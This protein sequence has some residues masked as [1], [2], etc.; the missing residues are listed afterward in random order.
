MVGLTKSVVILLKPVI[1]GIVFDPDAISE[2]RNQWGV[3]RDRHP[4]MSTAILTSDGE[5]R[6]KREVLNQTRNPFCL[7]QFTWCTLRGSH[8]RQNARNDSFSD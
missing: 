8:F 5:A 3:F 1:Y 6:G 4:E 7:A 2:I